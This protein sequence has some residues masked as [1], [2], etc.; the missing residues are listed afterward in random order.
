MP[1]AP[2]RR[3]AR[4]LLDLEHRALERRPVG[5]E[6]EA[7]P[8]RVGDHPGEPADAETDLQDA[9][10]AGALHHGVDDALCHSQLVHR[11][12]HP[13]WSAG[14]A[15]IGLGAGGHQTQ[16]GGALPPWTGVRIA[17]GITRCTLAW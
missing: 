12:S 14:Q 17:I 9:L 10:F 7:E 15:T 13:P 5:D 8:Q 4:V 6:V 11:G 16:A 1:H 2:A 3:T